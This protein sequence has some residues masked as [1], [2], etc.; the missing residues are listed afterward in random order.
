MSST[1]IDVARTQIWQVPFLLLYIV[2]LFLSLYRP[3]L[4]RARTYAVNGFSALIV[5]V[6]LQV[7]QWAQALSGTD[8]RVISSRMV[9]FTLGITIVKLAGF[10]LVMAGLFIDREPTVIPSPLGGK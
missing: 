9:V 8:Y 7:A 2:G 1:L 6:L 10:A 4:G 5:S 3:G